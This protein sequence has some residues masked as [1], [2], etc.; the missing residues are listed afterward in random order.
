MRSLSICRIC[1][2][3]PPARGGLAPGMLQLSLAQH[4]QGHKVTVITRATNGDSAY[5]ANLPFQVI[6][7]R[8]SKTYQFGWKAFNAYRNLPFRHDVVH[9]H[10][11]SAYYYLLRKKSADSP[12]VHTMHAVRKYQ[13]SLFSNLHSMVTTVANYYGITNFDK[14]S[15]YRFYTPHLVRELFLERQIC[16]K[17]DRL[18]VVAKYF[19]DQ[20]KE[21]YK[22]PLEK[23]DVS[24]NGSNFNPNVNQGTDSHLLKKYG[25]EKKH[26][27]ILYVGR[28]DWVKRVHL[29]VEAMPLI[30][31]QIPDAK[32]VIAGTGDQFEVLKSIARKLK[33][34]NDV[35]LLGWLPHDH[36]AVLYH[37]ARCFC[38]PSYWEGLSKSLIEAMSVQIPV[39]ATDN[40]ANR[41]VLENGRFGCLV[42]EPTPGRWSKCIL[43]VLNG[44]D[45]DKEKTKIKSGILEKYYRWDKV[46]ER[47]DA[48]YSK[49]I[50]G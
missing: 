6:R 47:I 19:A 13:Y 12:L 16:R 41:E 33:I 28:T 24:Y 25:L 1:E 30:R 3:F 48:A 7:I 49:A 23:I 8:C 9:T 38:L 34:E 14:P 31:E 37:S 35:K 45:S 27:V 20:I 32:L 44:R 40:L 2:Q 15:S 18:I 22:V 10:G 43:N 46:A 11:P 36:L 21:Y 17:A 5:D 26:A 29:L 39:I 50:Q 42:D 4:R